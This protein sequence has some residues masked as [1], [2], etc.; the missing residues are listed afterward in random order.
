MKYDFRNI[1]RIGRQTAGLTQARWAEAIDV[2]VEAVGQYETGV[3]MP[4]D[5]VVARMVEVSG[6]TV[7]GYWHLLNKSRVAADLLPDVQEVPLTQAVLGLLHEL[8]TW[9]DRHS[10]SSLISL[11]QDG[12]ITADED[13]V[14]SNILDDLERIVE[15]ALRLRFA[16]RRG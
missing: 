3:I 7:L 16:R 10:S 2:S 12:T 6:L 4:S 14:Y 15:A 1:S 9:D 5:D 13:K 11:T 8:Q